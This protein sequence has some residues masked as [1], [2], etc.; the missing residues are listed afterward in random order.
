MYSLRAIFQN[1]FLSQASCHLGLRIKLLI[2]NT[3]K[4]LRNLLI[5]WSISDRHSHKISDVLIQH[6]ADWENFLQ[7]SFSR[8]KK[9]SILR[10]LIL[11]SL[12]PDQE[13][14]SLNLACNWRALSLIHF[15]LHMPYHVSLTENHWHMQ[16][17][18]KNLLRHFH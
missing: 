4:I 1:L 14:F 18:V 13:I 17:W 10:H 16:H 12:N 8:D 5:S 2:H 6:F 7:K 3:L 15:S 9:S 11:N